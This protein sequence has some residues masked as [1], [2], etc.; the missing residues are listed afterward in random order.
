MKYSLS[1]FIAITLTSSFGCSSIP[2]MKQPASFGKVLGYEGC[3]IYG[4]L[5]TDKA[6]KIAK[7][8]VIEVPN[9]ELDEII[10]ESS[11]GEVYFFDCVHHDSSNIPSGTIFFGLVKSNVIIKKAVEIIEN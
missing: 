9:Q 4:P 6:Y 5:N 7:K 1:F 8:W 2:E 10:N 11:G 3:R